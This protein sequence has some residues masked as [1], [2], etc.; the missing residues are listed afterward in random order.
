MTAP[1]ICIVDYGMGNLN[2]VRAAFRFL[3]NEAVISDSAG[4][5]RAADAVVLPGV[6]AFGEAAANL[7]KS[8]LDAILS[9]QVMEK[10]KPFLGICLGMQLVG[11]GSDEMGRH[12]GLG[13]IDADVVSLSDTGALRVPHVGWS[14]TAFENG[15]VLFDNI[16]AGACFY[17]DHSYAMLQASAD[18]VATCDY[19]SRFV[20]AFRHGNVMAAQFHPE[21][22]QRAGLKLLRNFLNLVAGRPTRSVAA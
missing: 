2:S 3:G 19:G 22:S 7:A 9:E 10:K 13:W 14:E 8:G 5:L 16:E 20:A 18:S 11:R 4:D 1:R 15:E 6:G 17:Y 12:K 21:K